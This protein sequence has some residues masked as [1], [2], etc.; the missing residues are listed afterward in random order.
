MLIDSIEGDKAGLHPRRAQGDIVF[1]HT[2][3]WFL[4]CHDSA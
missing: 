4:L 3:A 2:T 1:Y